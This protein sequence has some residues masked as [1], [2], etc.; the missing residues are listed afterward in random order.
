MDTA[1]KEVVRLSFSGERVRSGAL[2]LTAL[3]LLGSFQRI[4]T[5]TARAAFFAANPGRLR[6][7][8]GFAERTVLFLRTV[9]RGSAVVPLET[10][11]YTEQSASPLDEESGD[12]YLERAADLVLRTFVAVDREER[13]PFEITRD[14]LAPYGDFSSEIPEGESVP[15]SIKDQG[16]SHDVTHETAGRI[17]SLRLPLYEDVFEVV[18]EVLEVDLKRGRFQLWLDEND[19][20]TLPI[21]AGQEPLV[22]G[23]LRDHASVRLRVRGRGRFRSDGRLLEVLELHEVG[24]L[25]ADGPRSAEGGTPLLRDL[26]MVSESIPKEVREALPHD[27]SAN[28]DHFLYGAPRR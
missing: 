26:L 5:E 11:S 25:N 28:L 17:G 20:L 24:E 15:L 1:W 10:P 3:G 9:E 27:F 19:R 14:T 21:S 18:G 8:K 12:D 7:P 23:A 16:R 22:I 4:V 6:V 2:D 13:L